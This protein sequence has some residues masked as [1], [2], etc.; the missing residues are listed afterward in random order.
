MKYLIL[1]DIH[2][3][4]EALQSVLLEVYSVR[5]DKYIVLGD[6]VGYGASPNEVLGLIR[7]KQIIAIRGNHDKV[8][9]GIESGFD[10]NYIAMDAALWTQENIT[11]DN[12]RYIAGLAQGPIS[13]DDDFDIIHGSP[14][15]EGF[16]LLN[17][18]HTLRAFNAITKDLTFFGHTHIPIIWSF[19]AEIAE[20]EAILVKEGEDGKFEYSLDR[21]K[22][23]LI[24]PG[25]VGQPRD[26]NPKASFAIFDSDEYKITFAR[27]SYD[28]KASQAK[29]IEAG[30]HEYLANRLSVGR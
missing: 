7:K 6:F 24:N 27:V 22:R 10:F 29:I 26:Y 5:F 19:D 18:R 13:V 17:E 21:G 30:L 28:I 8:A 20:T 15:D 11:I 4:L 9:A 3:N 25:S 12:K 14:W 1:S 2:S 23:Y 16:Y